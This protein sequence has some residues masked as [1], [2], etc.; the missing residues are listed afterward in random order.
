MFD[1]RVSITEDD[2]RALGEHLSSESPATSA[3]AF[4]ALPALL[5]EG[6]DTPRVIHA[7]IDLALL[8]AR[9]GLIESALYQVDELTKDARRVRDLSGDDALVER[10]DAARDL[11]EAAA[12][13]AS[14]ITK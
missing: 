14:A 8:T 12:N 9:E 11:I 2:Q 1:D 7:R 6:D 13:R 10:A 4:T 5:A 3:E